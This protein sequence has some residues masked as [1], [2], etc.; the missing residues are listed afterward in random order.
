MLVPL[1][2]ST[3]ESHGTPY[4]THTVACAISTCASACDA[5]LL[6]ATM[7]RSGGATGPDGVKNA[8][9]L[10]VVLYS[11]STTRPD[12]DCATASTAVA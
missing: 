10:L 5:L 4:L 7:S 12:A 9:T 11:S 8:S 6:L 3:A 1:S 2:S